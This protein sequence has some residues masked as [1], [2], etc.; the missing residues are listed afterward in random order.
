MAGGKRFGEFLQI[1]NG[2][3]INRR[4]KDRHV[5]L[6]GDVQNPDEGRTVRIEYD[7]FNAFPDGGKRMSTVGAT[8][9]GCYKRDL[10][11]TVTRLIYERFKDA[12]T[13]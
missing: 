6:L 5:T 9:E 8:I 4:R 7:C 11:E 13:K 2:T 12:G 1:E 3:A 10:R